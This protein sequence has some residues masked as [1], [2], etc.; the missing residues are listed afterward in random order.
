MAVRLAFCNDC[1]L[2]S[3]D[4]Y[5]IV[6]QEFAE[7]GIPA[8]DSFWL[9]DPSGGDFGLF[10]RDC[11]EKGP[12]HDEL[13]EEIAAGRL[14]VLHSTGSYGARFSQGLKPERRL[15]GEALEYLSKNARVPRV[16][17]NH[18]DENNTQNI[19]GAIPEHYHCGDLPSSDSFILDLLLEHG[20]EY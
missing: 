16:W 9:F 13:L 20:V 4:N 10:R 6:H 11:T 19:G 1:D 12:R 14:D 2:Q 15:I 18:G 17:T 7:R 3:W 8:G 5:R